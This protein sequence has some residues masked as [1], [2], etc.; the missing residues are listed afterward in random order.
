MTGFR[1]ALD[2]TS[3]LSPDSLFGPELEDVYDRPQRV[4]TRPVAC[5]SCTTMVV[6]PEVIHDVNGYYRA[7]GFDAPYRDIT[8]RALL[9]A[10]QERDGQTDEWLTRVF[11]L[12]LDPAERR[13]YDCAPLGRRHLDRIEVSRILDREKRVALARARGDAERARRILDE[14][15]DAQSLRRRDAEDDST[16]GQYP[17]GQDNG[18]RVVHTGPLPDEPEPWSWGYYRWGTGR[19]DIYR[20]GLWQALLVSALTA[21]E[22][23]IKFCVGY[24][25][26][27]RT[28][29]RF[30]VGRHHGAPVVYLR[31]DLFPDAEMACAAAFA[32]IRDHT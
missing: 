27:G 8:R 31:E 32:V 18:S 25:G 3:Y 12:L 19:A 14:R 7:L 17:G 15:L 29:S 6:V 1:A 21:Q 24:I 9:R 26:R 22:V 2:L 10:Y 16:T 30:V 28:D 11:A 23:T 5:S 20:L 13:C 4:G